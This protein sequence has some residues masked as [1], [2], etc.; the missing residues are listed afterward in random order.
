[1]KKINPFIRWWVTPLLPP[2]DIFASHNFFS[3]WVIHPVKRR[4]ARWYL[5]FLQR[6]TGIKVVAIT[7]STGK[8]TTTEIL[9]AILS[10]RQKTSWSQEGIDPVYNIPN[11]I[12]K[13]A[14]GTKYLVLE[15][16]V[17]YVNEMDYYLWLSKPDVAIVTNIATT[18]TQFLKNREGVAEEKKKLVKSLPQEGVAVLNM[19]DPIVKS[20]AQSTSA[21]VRWFGSGSDIFAE[22]IKL[23]R[24]L[25]T[26]F[27]LVIGPSK[28][29]VRM[30]VFGRQ[31]V[32]NALAAAAAAHSLDISLTDIVRG[33][34]KFKHPSHR[35]TV[36]KSPAY[37]IIFDDSYNSNP[38]AASES[39]DTFR[40]LAGSKTKIAVI[41][42]M[43]ELG[44]FEEPSHKELGKKVAKM[45]F[46]YLIAVGTAVRFT[47]EEARSS[48]GADK[49][50]LVSDV[51][52]AVPIV[53][54][55]ANSNS[56]IFVKG[57][58]SIALDRLVNALK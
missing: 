21:K 28:K 3:Q 52:E 48:I 10:T 11:T 45:G 6:Y 13:T 32:T 53:K 25:S 49:C 8:T 23:G 2:E 4:L 41:G 20:F 18:H 39:L 44:K 42:D 35:L 54:Q 50:F 12:L 15:M 7:G 34:E 57:S 36:I 29:T 1:M 9:G 16:S 5:R 37:G 19:E 17:E 51:A 22:K 24:D 47:I 33:I 43:L 31:F 56:A 26:S 27:T 30:N 46:D 14:W 58:R 55:L 38:K 40:S